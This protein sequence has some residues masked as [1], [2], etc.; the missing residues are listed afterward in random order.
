[1]SNKKLITVKNDTLNLKLFDLNKLG[2]V[3]ITKHGLF[4]CICRIIE[5]K[6]LIYNTQIMVVVQIYFCIYSKSAFLQL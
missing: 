5:T 2:T 6:K 1:M 4:L 3:I